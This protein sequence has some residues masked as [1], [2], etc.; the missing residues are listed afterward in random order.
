MTQDASPP[1]RR[2]IL[3]TGGIGA[4]AALAAAGA[5]RTAL[6][7]NEPLIDTSYADFVLPKGSC[8]DSLTRIQSSG[9]MV[10]VTSNDWPYSFFDTKTNEWSGLDADIIRFCAKMLK[11]PNLDVQTVTFDGMVPGLLSKRFDMIGDSIH[12]TKARAKI[13]DFSFPTYYYAEAL[14]VKKGNP[15]NL[16]QLTD[17]KGHTIGTLLGT[18]YAEWLQSVPGV[19]FQGYK[20]WAQMLPELA[21]GRLDGVLYDMPVVAM[22]LKDH[23]E[24]PVEI[25]EDYQPRTFKN[26]NGYSRYIFR[27]EDAQ[28]R[29]AFSAATEWME[30]NMEM[31]KIL[32]KWGLTGY[33]N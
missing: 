2:R 33:N 19:N 12:Y 14:S 1:S 17:C 7:A 16:H 20:D 26:P 29:S 10:V 30:Y 32:S 5:P 28:L 4:V 21:V 6:A 27:Q 9:K 22:S 25:V 24:W 31:S 3:A 8:D 18:N 13:V 23:P 11:I 15:L